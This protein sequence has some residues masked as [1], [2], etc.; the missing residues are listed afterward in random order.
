MYAPTKEQA[1]ADRDAAFAT[2]VPFGSPA[3]PSSAAATN[4]AAAANPAPPSRPPLRLRVVSELHTAEE[5]GSRFRPE[6]GG[7]GEVVVELDPKARVEAVRL[8]IRDATGIP[9][10]LCRLSYAGTRLED[11]Q[12]TLG[13]YGVAYWHAKFPQWPLVVTRC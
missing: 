4:A 10:A 6:D 5:Y 2:G 8:A 12:R 13:H 7:G 9:P 3:P 11:A 1:E